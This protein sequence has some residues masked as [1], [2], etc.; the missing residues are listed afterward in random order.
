MVTLIY[1]YIDAV[2]NEIYINAV[3]DAVINAGINAVINDV[4]YVLTYEGFYLKNQHKNSFAHTNTL[5]TING[6]HLCCH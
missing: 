4:T 2:I 3:L 1:I 5:D 6:C